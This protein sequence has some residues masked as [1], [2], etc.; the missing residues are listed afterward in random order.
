MAIIQVVEDLWG[1]DS[2]SADFVEVCSKLWSTFAMVMDNMRCKDASR[3]GLGNL[4]KLCS[5]LVVLWAA[6]FPPSGMKK[7][8]LHTVVHHAGAGQ[9]Y[10]LDN[11]KTCLGM[12]ENSGFE[13]RHYVGRT[14]YSKIMSGIAR[15]DAG[16]PNPTIYAT[17]RVLFKW[18]HG[19]D[20]V[21]FNKV[22]KQ[23]GK[24]CIWSFADARTRDNTDTV[25]AAA[26]AAAA[27]AKA[28]EAAAEAEAEASAA[29]SAA[30]AAAVAEAE[31]AE[32][33]V[34]GLEAV[35]AAEAIEAEEAAEAAEAEAAEAADLSFNTACEKERV[36][37]EG[38]GLLEQIEREAFAGSSTGFNA[39]ST[40]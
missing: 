14:A 5:Q 24:D 20:L 6:A 12:F 29:P 11:Y 3:E 8:Y 18:Q 37:L 32:E 25:A 13:K 36:F 19:S 39:R 10:L 31:E 4:G 2:R 17:A 16:H 33:A 23:L 1:K 21:S 38:Q 9:N 15:V 34:E 7:F 26:A 35:V 27:T 30:A 40:F 22:R 28:A